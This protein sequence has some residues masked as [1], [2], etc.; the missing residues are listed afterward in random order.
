MSTLRLP[1]TQARA[2]IKAPAG[3]DAA[4]GTSYDMVCGPEVDRRHLPL[5]AP[6]GVI[7]GDTMIR[8]DVDEALRQRL[9]VAGC[10]RAAAYPPRWVLGYEMGPNPLWLTEALAADIGPAPGMRVLD[11]GCGN[12]V[13]SVFLAR[14]F[15]VTVW[16]A[17]LWIDPV[18]SKP[19]R[20][21]VGAGQM[22]DTHCYLLIKN[23]LILYVYGNAASSSPPSVRL[24]KSSM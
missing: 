15:E 1:P 8:R 19:R 7:V 16:A 9:A 20:T 12:A 2:D 21:A 3:T 23:Y 13:T 6:G 5:L 10:P 18:A 11:L 17:D 22:P 4:L 14:E 24:L